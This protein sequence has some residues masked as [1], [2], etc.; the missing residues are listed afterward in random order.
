MYKGFAYASELIIGIAYLII[1]FLII[2]YGQKVA[3]VFEL[4]FLESFE[5]NRE[6]TFKVIP[7]FLD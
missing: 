2:Y 7:S 3:N 5:G 6:M 1:G 4:K